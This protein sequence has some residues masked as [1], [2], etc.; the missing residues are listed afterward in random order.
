M[1]RP[2]L[3][4][5]EDVVGNY[6]GRPRI[7]LE[8]SLLMKRMVE[9]VKQPGF[10]PDGWTAVA[11]LLAVDDFERV[12]NFKEVMTWPEYR[13]FLTAWAGSAEWDCSFKRVIESDDIV[14]LELEE[15][16]EVG[17]FSSVVNS[18][19]VYEFDGLDKIRHIDVYLQMALPGEALPQAYDKVRLAD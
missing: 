18:I 14:F 17:H 6:S 9:V 13:D 19:S 12:G 16:S 7:V 15:R 8:Y 2:P 3:R 1:T 10:G 11:D 5:V 4:K